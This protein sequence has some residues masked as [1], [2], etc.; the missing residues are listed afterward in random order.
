MARPKALTPNQVKYLKKQWNRQ[1][2]ITPYLCHV[3]DISKPTM[4]KALYNKG[5]YADE[6]VYGPPATKRYKRILS[7]NLSKQKWC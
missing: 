5:V 1:D 4:V 6:A 2:S 7:Y 3:Y